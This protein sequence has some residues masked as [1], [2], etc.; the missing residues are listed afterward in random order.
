M[1]LAELIKFGKKR[2]FSVCGIE[3]RSGKSYFCSIELFLFKLR[4]ESKFEDLNHD[5]WHWQPYHDQ[6]FTN[7]DHQPLRISLYRDFPVWRIETL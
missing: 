3:S 1:H 7:K 4:Y 5:K 6:V 2:G